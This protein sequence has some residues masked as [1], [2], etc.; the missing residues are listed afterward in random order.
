MYLG[1]P[2]PLGVLVYIGVLHTS[3][4]SLSKGRAKMVCYIHPGSQA[5]STQ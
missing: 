1:Q 3:A 2:P 5:V 4:E